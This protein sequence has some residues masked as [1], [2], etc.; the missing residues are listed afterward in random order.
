MKLL[1]T[2]R[3][4]VENWSGCQAPLASPRH[5]SAWQAGV[6]PCFVPVHPSRKSRLAPKSPNEPRPPSA[7][8]V[9]QSRRSRDDKHS[10]F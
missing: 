9:G 5:R 1:Q 8:S 7:R 10:R 2:P 4:M 6:P 3:S